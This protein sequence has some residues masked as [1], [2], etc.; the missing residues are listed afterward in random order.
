MGLSNLCSRR[1]IARSM[2]CA[3]IAFCGADTVEA[4]LPASARAGTFELDACAPYTSDSGVFTPTSEGSVTAA[5][6]CGFTGPF[7]PALSVSSGAGVVPAGTHASW[8]TSA[9]S[10]LRIVAAVVPSMTAFGVNEKKGWGGGFFYEGG[11]S[12]VN[13]LTDNFGMF[14]NS[15][16]FGFQLVCGWAT[17]NGSQHPAYIE[18]QSI[19][20]WILETTGPWILA[21]TPFYYQTGWVRGVWPLAFTTDDV[22]GV[23]HTEVDVDQQPI[24]GPT[25]PPDHTVWHQCSDGGFINRVNTASYPD[26][27]M[28]LTLG[29]TNAAGVSSAPTRTLYVDNTPVGISIA[30]PDENTWIN[31]GTT[32]TASASAGPSGVSGFLCGVDRGPL[33]W[34][35]GRSKQFPINGSG[36]HS[37]SCAAA[38]NAADATG[39]VAWSRSDTRVVKIDETPPSSVFEPENPSDPEQFVVD[40]SDVGSGVAG[41]SVQMRPAGGQW[42]TLPTQFDGRHLLARF[43]DSGLSGAY[44]FQATSCDLVGNCST[45][46]EQLTLPVR[47]GSISSLSFARIVNPLHARRVH[48]RVLVGFH[49]V[50][51]R[52]HG[53]TTRVK[54]GGHWRRITEIRWQPKCSHKR[55]KVGHRRWHERTVCRPPR[56]VLSTTRRVRYGRGVTVHGLLRTSQGV[57]LPG[58]IVHILGAPDNGSNAFGELTAAAT[59]ADG[60]WSAKL[61]AGPSRIIAAVYNGTATVQPSTGQA[62]TIVP[63]SVKLLHVTPQRVAWGGTIHI[64][65]QLQGGYLPSDGALVRLRIGFAKAFVTYG[66]KEHVTGD[67]VFSTSYTFGAGVSSIVRRYRFQV[68]SLPTGEYPYAPARSRAISVIVGGHPPPPPT[69]APRQHRTHHHQNRRR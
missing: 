51:V 30:G 4:Q 65:G 38:N 9:P 6:E 20:L 52:R 28:I 41:G 17:C 12:G 5:D 58:Q 16:Y 66:V 2:L 62:R 69:T 43:S 42:Q 53:K 64:T 8:G 59:A 54:R 18:V 61:P 67:G 49:W 47:V 56:L 13:N 55:V 26:G 68:G 34:S 27:P 7:S 33:R 14:M 46:D 11:G 23:C 35:A 10:G 44:Q 29:A 48:R 19:R 45:S 22:S 39:N 57:A 15:S 60:S 50:T 37:V 25:S 31:H 36:V 32:L 24:E 1:L 40:T 21:Q 3:A 63:A